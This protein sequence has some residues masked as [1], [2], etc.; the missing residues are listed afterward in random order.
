MWREKLAELI[1]VRKIIALMMAGTFVVLAFMGG[2]DPTYI[3]STISL[4]LGYYFG[5]ST[6][7]DKTNDKSEK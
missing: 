7:L 4:V 2:L 6:A 1:G 3:Y 5:K